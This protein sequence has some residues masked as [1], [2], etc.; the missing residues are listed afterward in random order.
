M[1]T[2]NE[3]GPLTPLYILVILCTV[4]LSALMHSRLA[5]AATPQPPFS[6][7]DGARP[8]DGIA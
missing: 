8:Q 3:E 7:L 5:S 1:S 6:S 2:R 4:C